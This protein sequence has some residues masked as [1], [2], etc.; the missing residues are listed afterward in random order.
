MTSR[1]A[2]A[3]LTS[4]ALAGAVS[5]CGATPTRSA[6]GGAPAEGATARA[7]ALEVVL[8]LRARGMPIGAVAVC[9]P[10]APAPPSHPRP[11]AVAF[12]DAR[13]GTDDH[14]HVIREGGVV[15]VLGSGSAVD[16]RVREL[17]RQSL[18]AQSYGFDEGGRP[19]QAEHRL[20]RGS[21][22]LRL[23]GDLSPAAV[24]DYEQALRDILPVTPDFSQL[25]TTEEAPCST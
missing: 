16:A 25:D 23:S 17:D 13:V 11:R 24:G 15:E 14:R 1:R 7:T 19:L 18:D 8:G 10:P 3:L 5:A 9:T 2:A 4:L 21:V 22:L 12:D 6:A 20:T